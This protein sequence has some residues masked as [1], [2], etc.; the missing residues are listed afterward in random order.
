MTLLGVTWILGAFTGIPELRLVFIYLSTICN[1]LQ[2][3]LIFIVRC[4]YHKEARLAWKYLMETGELK[5][6]RGTRP[7]GSFFSSNSKTAT[8]SHSNSSGMVIIS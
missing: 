2:G 6:F 4:L 3:L 8:S 5:K 7:S 1:S